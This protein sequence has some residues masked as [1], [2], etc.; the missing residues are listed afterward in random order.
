MDEG[1]LGESLGIVRFS[2]VSDGDVEVAIWTE[3]EVS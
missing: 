2:S 1:V 3:D